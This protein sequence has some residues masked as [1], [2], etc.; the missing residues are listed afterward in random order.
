MA[1][2]LIAAAI[3]FWGGEGGEKITPPPEKAT[4]EQQEAAAPSPN[5]QT[6]AEPPLV[7][8]L[9]RLAGKRFQRRT[10]RKQLTG[11]NLT[12]LRIKVLLPSQTF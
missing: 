2:A 12:M 5:G 10:R 8:Q 4:A 11:G 1:S 3:V 6:A 9:I 7:R